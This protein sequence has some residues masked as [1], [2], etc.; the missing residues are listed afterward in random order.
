M[1]I[2]IIEYASNQKGR[3]VQ[4]DR[5]F[6]DLEDARLEEGLEF[7]TPVLTVFYTQ[8]VNRF[9]WVLTHEL[10]YLVV[11]LDVRVFDLSFLLD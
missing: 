2:I 6:L 10:Y 8:G 9:N 7:S 11:D 4:E 5:L 3:A 1:L